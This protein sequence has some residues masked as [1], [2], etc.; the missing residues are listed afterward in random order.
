MRLKSVELKV[1]SL[2]L[3]LA[4]NFTDGRPFSNVVLAF[5]VRLQLGQIKK[6]KQASVSRMTYISGASFNGI[7][8]YYIHVED[9]GF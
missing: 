6:R 8:I 2:D 3:K 7:D 9:P 5:Q 4:K 1:Y